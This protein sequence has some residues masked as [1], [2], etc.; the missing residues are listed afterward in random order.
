MGAQRKKNGWHLAEKSSD[1]HE[2][3]G[4]GLDQAPLPVG[5]AGPLR[6]AKMGVHKKV[7][8]LNIRGST[9]GS[10]RVRRSVPGSVGDFGHLRSKFFGPAGLLNL[11][12]SLG[13]HRLLNEISLAEVASIWGASVRGVLRKL[14]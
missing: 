2:N 14:R 8:F 5:R 1:P 13:S 7:L 10:A 4:I 6:L 12:G 3:F 11:Q 9:P